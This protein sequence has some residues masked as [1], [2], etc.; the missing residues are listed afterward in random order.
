MKIGIVSDTHS[1]LFALETVLGHMESE[2]V[3]L[4]VHLGDIIGYGPKP[5]ETLALTLENFNYIVMGNHDLAVIDPKESEYFNPQAKKAVEWTRNKLS[6]EEIDVLSNLKY[7]HLINDM[8]FVHG[9][10]QANNP[11][12]YMLAVSDATMAFSDPVADFRVAFVGHTHQPFVWREDSY[13]R[14]ISRTL[15]NELGKNTIQV[16]EGRTIFNVGSVG[17]PRDNDPRA[18]YAIYDTHKEE[19]T[20]YKIP[21]SIE[22]TVAS[23]QRNGF[24]Q[25]SYERLI[26]GR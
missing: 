14:V 3:D 11:H 12:G 24:D 9:S 17:Q 25:S 4:K 5:N 1:N 2:G 8:L 16:K 6:E 19:V 22:K 21:Y 18:S 7:G 23:M 13:E 20:F 26:Y 10:P 15:R